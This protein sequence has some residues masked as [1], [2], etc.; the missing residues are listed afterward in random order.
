[1]K[2]ALAGTRY[3]LAEVGRESKAQARAGEVLSLSPRLDSWQIA[4]LVHNAPSLLFVKRWVNL[5]G[6]FLQRF[7]SISGV[8]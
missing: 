1:M 3:I 4:N 6:F 5:E 2:G 8:K 7:V